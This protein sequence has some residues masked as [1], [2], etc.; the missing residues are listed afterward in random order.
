MQHE[1]KSNA[2]KVMNDIVR[3]IE[4]RLG[5]YFEEGDED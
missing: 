5:E 4:E 3:G 2:R 1:C